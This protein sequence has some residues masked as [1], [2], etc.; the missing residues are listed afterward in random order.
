G[1]AA[2][3]EPARAARCRL[4]APARDLARQHRLLA[5]HS[6]RRARTDA[7]ALGAA[8]APLHLPVRGVPAAPARRRRRR[9]GARRAADRQSRPLLG[10]GE[11]VKTRLPPVPPAELPE[12]FRKLALADAAAGRDPAMNSLLAHLPGFFA[13]YFDFYYPAHERGVVPT[14]IKELA[15]LRIA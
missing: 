14:R 15:R 1:G 11:P 13:S 3:Q 10:G 2:H 9:S 8:A 5:L 4:R 6:R 7:P 12:P